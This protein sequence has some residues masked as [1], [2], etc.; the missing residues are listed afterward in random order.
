MRR[1]CEKFCEKDQRKAE[2]EQQEQYVIASTRVFLITFKL[3][4]CVRACPIPTTN[5]DLLI[6]G[7]FSLF[8]NKISFIGDL[9][10]F[11]TLCVFHHQISNFGGIFLLAGFHI[12]YKDGS[13]RI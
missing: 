3:T 5:C 11:P 2:E 8:A 6:K 13:A 4:E 12:K 1:L 7:C 9:T 10:R